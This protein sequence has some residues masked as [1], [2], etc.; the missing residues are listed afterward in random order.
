MARRRLNR[1]AFAASLV[2]SLLA[3]A[4]GSGVEGTYESGIK[5]LTLHGGGKATYRSTSRSM[6]TARV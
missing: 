1:V 3:S 6:T 2:A 4:C 5:R